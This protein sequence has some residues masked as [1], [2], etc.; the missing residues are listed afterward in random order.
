MLR[1][2]PNF[3]TL[4]RGLGGVAVSA[5][6]LGWGLNVLAFYV[7]IAAILT[8][9]VDGWLA[10]KLGAESSFGMALDAVCDKLLTD[11]TWLSL[12]YLGWAPW[13]LAGGMLAR[14]A[15]V[16]VGYSAARLTGRRWRASLMARVAISFEGVTL[17]FLLLHDRM[18]DVHWYTAGVLMGVLALLVSG[19][20]AIEYLVR[21]PEPAKDP[22]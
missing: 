17:P 6:L 3:V 1:W 20:S 4:L 5:L 9:L 16:I 21:G 7:F 12:L 8:D 2:L 19:A 22:H 10:K 11:L 18:W 13:W 14:D 15:L